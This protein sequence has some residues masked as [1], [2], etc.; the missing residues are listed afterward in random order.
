MDI[1]LKGKPVTSGN[2]ILTLW[3]W[4]PSIST[5]CQ[6]HY[7]AIRRLTRNNWNEPKTTNRGN[8][9]FKVRK[10]ADACVL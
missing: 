2:I 3:T 8:E 4:T 9:L 6:N 5:C 10:K 7:L 1:E